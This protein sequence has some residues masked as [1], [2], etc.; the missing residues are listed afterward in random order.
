MAQGERRTFGNLLGGILSAPFKVLGKAFDVATSPIESTTNAVNWVKE[1]AESR[2]E[3]RDN[4]DRVYARREISLAAEEKIASTESVDTQRSGRRGFLGWFTD[5]FSGKS[6]KVVQVGDTQP[7]RPHFDLPVASV[8][9]SSAPVEYVEEDVKHFSHSIDGVKDKIAQ[10]LKTA[11]GD[12]NSIRK[13]ELTSPAYDNTLANMGKKSH[14]KVNPQEIVNEFETIARSLDSD[15]LSNLE[16]ADALGRTRLKLMEKHSEGGLPQF[17]SD[18]VNIETLGAYKQDIEA[19]KVTPPAP[20]PAPTYRT[21]Q[22]VAMDDKSDLLKGL[23]EALSP[24]VAKDGDGKVD[25]VEVAKLLAVVDRGND[26]VIHNTGEMV[27]KSAKLLKNAGDDESK[28]LEVARAINDA[29]KGTAPQDV[30]L[31]TSTFAEQIAAELGK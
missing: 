8:N 6:N 9:Q 10:L 14:I 22:E 28:D 24:Y 17:F 25:P 23:A 21:L 18:T 20:K 11:T 29:L 3:S 15:R 5:L 7:A 2:R 4:D 13:S 1:R 27:S 12:D 16:L 30:R 31:A 19:P 26:G